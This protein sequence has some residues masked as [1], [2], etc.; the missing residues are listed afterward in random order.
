[1]RAISLGT[2]AFALLLAG[3]AHTRMDEAPIA[4][5]VVEPEV[6]PAVRMPH[7]PNIVWIEY[8]H[9][10]K[11]SSDFDTPENL[12]NA[13][14]VVGELKKWFRDNAVVEG[15]T[16][17][18]GDEDYNQ[19]LGLRRAQAVCDYLVLKGISPE[20]LSLRSCGEKVPAVP[21]DSEK[22]RA[23]N[24]RVNCHLKRGNYTKEEVA[25]I[26]GK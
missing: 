9:F 3:C 10:K 23:Y 5:P 15:H 18:I 19:Q 20:R 22:N 26:Y 8:I 2:L 16:C 17:D 24:R 12:A 11:D 7:H 13:D 4:T 6:Q 14:I 21:N 25:A 1:M